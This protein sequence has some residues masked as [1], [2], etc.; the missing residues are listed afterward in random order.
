[1]VPPDGMVRVVFEAGFGSAWTD[2]PV[3]LRQAVLLL[4]AEYYEHRHD[5]G[6]QGAGFPFGVVTLIERWRN[7]RLLGGKA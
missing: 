3:D 4:A 1:M 6:T 7:V 2:I 5:D